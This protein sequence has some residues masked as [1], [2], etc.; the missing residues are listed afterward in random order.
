LRIQRFS[1]REGALLARGITV[2]I[3]VFRAFTCE[4]L[5]YHY[6]AG[7]IILES[8]I[9]TC[10]HYAGTAILIGEKDGRFIE[11]FDLL[12]SPWHIMARGK[13]NFNNRTVVHRTT[14]GVTG[15][16]AA[17]NH[18]DEVLLA[19]YVNARATAQY[20]RNLN[21]D[22]V[23]IVAMGVATIKKTPEDE[24][25]GDYIENLLAQTPYDH[26][27]ALHAILSDES[28]QKFL[29]G[30]KPYYPKE[31]PSICLQRDVFDSALRVEREGELLTVSK[32]NPS[33]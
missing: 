16:V 6:G 12:N 22:L 29:R 33:R 31:D 18:S 14:S 1:Q 2:I 19:S 4:P 26:I 17:M 32:I 8:D 7:K 11:G 24:F 13:E 10:R 5:M 20:I 21:P 3:D 25:C 15:A 27:R 23:S 9:E 30:D 28:A